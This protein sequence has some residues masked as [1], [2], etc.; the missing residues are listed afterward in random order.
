MEQILW[1]LTSY[2]TST[3][4]MPLVRAALICGLL[5]QIDLVIVLGAWLLRKLGVLPQHVELEPDN[6]KSAILVMPTLLRT[7]A[8]LEGLKAAMLSAATNRYPGRLF[9]VACIDGVRESGHLVA[10]LDAWARRQSIPAGVE[11]HV[12][13][14]A[15]RQGKAVAM[16]AGVEHMQG[17]IASGRVADFPELFFNMDADSTLGEGALERMA[18]RLTRRRLLRGTP[19]HIVTSNVVVPLEQCYRGWRSLLRS[20]HWLALLV[21]RE[22]LSS[23]TIGKYNWKIFPR[24]EVSGALYCT[25]SEAHLAAPYYA[26]FMQTLTFKDWLKWWMGYPPPRFSEFRGEALPE[27]MTGP[28]DDTWMGWL[29]ATASWKDG[30]LCL[31]AP[32]TPMHA[33]GRFILGYFSRALAYDPLIKVYSKTPTTAKAL[34]KQRLRWNSSRVQDM[35]RWTKSHLYHWNVG[36][37]LMLSTSVVVASIVLFA[38][39]LLSPLYLSYL[40]PATLPFAILAGAGYFVTRITSTVAALLISDSPPSEWIKLVALPFSG[41]YHVVFN[42][43][44]LLIG[45]VRDIFG[46]GEPTTFAPETTLRNSNLSRIA[47]AYRL[48]RAILLAVRAT[49]RGDVPFGAFWFG[50]KHTPWTP[51]G[52]DGWTSGQKPPPVYW[53]RGPDDVAAGGGDNTHPGG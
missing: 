49:V 37:P 35:K 36:I 23:I 50:W 40:P 16:H 33:L 38:A 11:L 17:L 20:R 12:A 44:T 2:G 9:V 41:I 47:L 1:Y 19:Y 45:Y 30:H 34:F 22:Y 48:R 26:R 28:G 21:A 39:T 8:E 53:R 27:A 6:R 24:S 32:R 43:L 42:T 14:T 7:P 51:S 10:D 18:Y 46:F 5:Y 15:E 29:A 31:D 25:W 3:G 13:G 4:L 52:F